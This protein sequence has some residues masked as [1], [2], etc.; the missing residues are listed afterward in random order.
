MR[1]LRLD[2]RAYAHFSNYSIDF[3]KNKNIHVLYGEN[4]AGKTSIA[5]SLKALLFG[6]E[7]NTQDAFL[8]PSEH[9]FIAGTLKSTQGKYIQIH[10]DGSSNKRTQLSFLESFYSCEKR[11]LLNLFFLDQESIYMGSKDL[12]ENIKH[13]DISLFTSIQGAQEVLEIL[14][15]IEQET[16]NLFKE[17]GVK[18]QINQKIALIEELQKQKKNLNTSK[19]Q[20]DE[21]EKECKALQENKNL[22]QAQIKVNIE[23]QGELIL[24]HDHYWDL[25][26]NQELL[27]QSASLKNEGIL[28]QEFL[29]K[30][31]QSFKLQEEKVRQISSVKKE[32]CDLETTLSKMKL[33][34]K[35]LQRKSDIRVLISEHERIQEFLPTEKVLNKDLQELKNIYK[36]LNLDLQ[37]KLCSS[38][39]ES[40]WKRLRSQLSQISENLKV[41]S[42]ISKNLTLQVESYQIQLQNIGLE[43][44][45]ES[46]KVS[47]RKANHFLGIVQNKFD[48]NLHY[49]S[50]QQK[51]NERIL[52]YNE[53]KIFK[54][55]PVNLSLIEKEKFD[56]QKINELI[57][58]YYSIYSN[59]SSCKSV[60]SSLQKQIKDLDQEK[61]LFNIDLEFYFSK[62]SSKFQIVNELIKPWN[63][64]NYLEKYEQFKSLANLILYEDQVEEKLFKNPKVLIYEDEIAQLKKQ[65]EIESKRDQE[66]IEKLENWRLFF[67]TATQKAIVSFDPFE[68]KKM[69]FIFQCLFEWNQLID[70]INIEA[71]FG[72]FVSQLKALLQISDGDIAI[73][74]IV[75]SLRKFINETSIQIVEAEKRNQKIQLYKEAIGS[76]LKQKEDEKNDAKLETQWKAAQN[77]F[78][79]QIPFCEESIDLLIEKMD[80]FFSLSKEIKLKNNELTYF[81]RIFE[82]FK[83]NWK[84]TLGLT[85][86]NPE[87]IEIV[88]KQIFEVEKIKLEFENLSFL[89]QKKS[90]FLI[91][92]EQ[93][94]QALNESIQKLFIHYDLNLHQNFSEEIAKANQFYSL[95]IEIQKIQEN[96]RL[97]DSFRD[98]DTLFR[99]LEKHENIQSVAVHLKNI[100]RLLISSKEQIS[101]LDKE[102]G[103]NRY[104]QSLIFDFKV[105]HE[106]EAKL[107]SEFYELNKLI[108]AYLIAKGGAQY[109]KTQILDF[110]KKNQQSILHSAAIYFE[111]LTEGKYC[112][113]NLNF[114]EGDQSYLECISINK[115]T[116]KVS[117]LSE[118]TRDQLFLALKL[119]FLEIYAEKNDPLPL[120][121][122]DILVNFDDQRAARCIEIIHKFSQKTQILFLTHHKHLLDLF[123]QTLPQTSVEFL[124]VDRS[125][126]DL[127]KS[128]FAQ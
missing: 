47:L 19:E 71:E 51:I 70:W 104:K 121:L 36:K 12:I 69:T 66:N 62:K 6:I 18:P 1:L 50:L 8:H 59:Y 96:F 107:Q 93:E 13:F 53:L 65:L 112:Q 14:K 21:L 102:I 72:S 84:K 120:I 37:N 86:K 124:K 95:K 126:L 97:R 123:K 127:N 103:A 30:Y 125:S 17:R 27:L 83:S 85:Y 117:Q 128:M 44:D 10:R 118:G 111:Q 40:N 67:K 22:L 77:Q 91:L 7:K 99:N 16:E 68:E 28:N 49:R 23:K 46:L 39:S 115:K 75:F 98:L 113:L 87:D 24:L 15:K 52:K 60:L 114:L 3:D 108:K 82:S 54:M 88:K 38:I 74:N 78:N 106:I 20:Y 5:R 90:E 26:K 79:I 11:M 122:D 32:I 92:F 73:N 76:I 31:N 58:E 29:E 33:E 64:K 101:S 63:D 34:E 100:E 109:L 61:K 94:N 81:H 41:R 110:Q 57:K 43:V 2:L 116:L 48:P 9:L 25:K 4:E 45:V 89:K 119:A 80:Q 35:L 56:E 105:K 42:K 55:D